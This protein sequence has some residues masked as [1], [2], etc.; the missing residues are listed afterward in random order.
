MH[1]QEHQHD[2]TW[3]SN[4]AKGCS[5]CD[6][7]QLKE[8]ERLWNKERTKWIVWYL[9]SVFRSNSCKFACQNP[10]WD[11]Q[12]TYTTTFI[13]GYL[14][15]GTLCGLGMVPGFPSWFTFKSLPLVSGFGSQSVYW[16]SS[17]FMGVHQDRHCYKKPERQ[18]GILGSTWVNETKLVS[19][20]LLRARS[21]EMG[22]SAPTNGFLN[23]SYKSSV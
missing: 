7:A 19:L 9:R 5:F 17:V 6:K 20:V 10:T 21:L 13:G 3:V 18:V 23:V 14:T 8:P 15:T 1:R 2:R 16:F 12:H 22:H 11:H 4:P